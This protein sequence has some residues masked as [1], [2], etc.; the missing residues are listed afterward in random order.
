MARNRATIF[1]GKKSAN[2][3]IARRGIDVGD[4][5]IFLSDGSKYD[6]G[7]ILDIFAIRNR[8]AITDPVYPVY[9]DT[10]VMAGH[11]GPA[12]SDGSYEG[13]VYLPCTAANDFVPA[14]P[15]EA[16]DLVYLCFPNTHRCGGFSG[17]TLAGWNT[18]G[19]TRLFLLLMPRLRRLH[20]R[21]EDSALDLRDSGARECAIEFRS[22]SKTGGFT[23]VR[24][25]FTVMPK[26]LTAGER[27]QEKCRFTSFMASAVEH[28][29]Q[30]REL[31]GS[32]SRR[33]AL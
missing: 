14:P 2:T 24:C 25:G 5:E 18:R 6:C 26:S 3:I 1:C 12:R 28:E 16:V 31:P 15:K 4:D 11:T 32:A 8:I 23:G 29:G 13:I 10:N 9:V 7:Y 30:Q 21:S 20:K 19:S 27:R 22:F 17:T 33:S